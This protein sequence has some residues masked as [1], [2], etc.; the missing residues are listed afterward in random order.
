MDMFETGDTI[1]LGEG[2]HLI[3]GSN[4]LQEGGTIIGISNAESTIISSLEPDMSSSLFDLSGNEVLYASVIN[5]L[6]T[7]TN[8]L[9]LLL[10]IICETQQ[11]LLRNICVDLGTLQA[12]VIIRKDC[13]VLVT[14][15][16]IRISNV[17]ASSSAKWG[18]V[19]MPGA[20]LVFEN[21]V[22]QGLGTAVIIYG[23]GE[24]VMNNCHFEGCCEGVR[25]KLLRIDLDRNV[26]LWN[27]RNE[28][29]SSFFSSMIMHVLPRPNA[30]SNTS[31]TDMP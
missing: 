22:F 12:G 16:R 4:G 1:L 17:A 27:I 6:T 26:T 7:L 31:K 13:T 18:A 20:K 19:V 28:S 10:L 24:V 3:K 8:F 30:P 29:V 2:N 21:T 23:T 5:F 14:G 11:I 25:V 9:L 15:C